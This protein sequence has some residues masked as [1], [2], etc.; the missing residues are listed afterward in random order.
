MKKKIKKNKKTKKKL[1]N[2]E[3]YRAFRT[4]GCTVWAK[5][6]VFV[7]NGKIWCASNI[8]MDTKSGILK[9]FIIF[10][11][12]SDPALFIFYFYFILYLLL[13]LFYYYFNIFYFLL[14]YNFYY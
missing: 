11:A 7:L 8:I 1:K 5:D 14:N 13:L 12:S 2:L 4:E 6:Q 9:S 3:W 10:S